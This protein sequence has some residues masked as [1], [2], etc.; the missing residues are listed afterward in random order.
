MW[1]DAGEK[2]KDK[3]A[4]KEG[5]EGW[6]KE[7][8]TQDNDWGVQVAKGWGEQAFKGWAEQA[9]KG[10]GEQPSKGWGEQ[11]SKGW[12]EQ[13]PKGWGEQAFKGWGEQAFKGWA[14]EKAK[15]W[16]E[17]KREGWG[18][19]ARKG[20]GDN[21][22]NDWGDDKQRG[23]GGDDKKDSS[24]EDRPRWRWGDK[25]E[26]DKK[27]VWDHVRRRDRDDEKKWDREEDRERGDR[28]KRRDDE[29]DD[30]DKP[31]RKDNDRDDEDDDK[32][33]DIK[34]KEALFAQ[35][36]EWLKKQEKQDDDQEDTKEYL[37]KNLV[38]FKEYIKRKA[39]KEEE[40]K[41]AKA[42]IFKQMEKVQI[43]KMLNEKLYSLT[44]EYKG[45]KLNFMYEIT[46]HFL[47][48][49]KCDS[50]KS[51]LERI[52]NGQYGS[53]DFANDIESKNFD[54]LQFDWGSLDT[55]NFTLS[56]ST[57]AQYMM[58]PTKKLEK[59]KWFD[60]L[61]RDEQVK[62]ILH[63]YIQLMCSSAKQLTLL[64]NQ[65]EPDYLQ[66]RRSKHG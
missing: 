4:E 39:L 13:A 29:K 40:E 32:G 14:E 33:L 6:G 41:E 46:E 52:Y 45:Q 21:Q 9:S 50:S 3:F 63:E 43:K 16:G 25:E 28:R 47:G 31:R 7:P 11:P 8:E 37:K 36:K 61:S 17:E 12:G 62:F 1:V 10:W 53:P 58:D 35:F 54:T 44:E 49:C 65:A 23:W 15:E 66:Y 57:I 51:A 5:A 60:S 38:I 59:M 64:L 20:W 34:E 18:E 24:E 19:V 42:A 55:M 27:K 22:R 56:N 48:F 2:I 26:D 30:D